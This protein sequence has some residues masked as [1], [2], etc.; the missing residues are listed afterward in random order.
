MSPGNVSPVP[1]SL[2]E[3]R[4]AGA[5]ERH[6][7]ERRRVLCAIA[8]APW[9]ARGVRAADAVRYPN[10]PIHLVLPSTV[11]GTSDLIARLIESRLAEA[12]GQ[13]VVIEARPGASGRIALERVASAAPDVYTL[14]LANNGVNAIVPARR[15]AEGLD[16]TQSFAPVSLLARLPIVIVV[17]PMLAADSLK[18]LVALARRA[19]G[20]LSYASSGGGST[21]HLAAALLFQ[22]A[23]VRL[24]HVPYS[25]TSAAVKDVLSGE[26]PVLFSHLGTVAT[27]VRAGQLRALAVTGDHRMADFPDL[28]TVAESGYPGFDITTWHGIVAPAN[29]PRDIVLRLNAELARVVAHADVRRQLAAMGMEPVAGTPEQFAAAINADVV[30]QAALMRSLPAADE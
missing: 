22:R 16:G 23:D 3:H 12:L 14:L 1:A 25:G 4:V 18:A 10:R 5:R 24:V 8:A 13:P 7:R 15:E 30:R 17:T 2:E 20:R 19:P 21:S 9:L 6:A 28:P 11:G 27:L 29:T 26:V